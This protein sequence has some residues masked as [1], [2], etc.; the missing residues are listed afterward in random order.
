MILLTNR[1]E[2]YKKAK[3]SYMSL[4][5]PKE[6]IA[7]AQVG[8]SLEDHLMTWDSQL[9]HGVM[10]LTTSLLSMIQLTTLIDST[11]KITIG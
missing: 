4:T 10:V 2:N 6:E 11:S 3:L 7:V 8:T 1:T 9:H 5:L